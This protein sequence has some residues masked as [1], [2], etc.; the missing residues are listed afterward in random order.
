MQKH[1]PDWFTYIQ[2]WPSYSSLEREIF[3][4]SADQQGKCH[5]VHL[6]TASLNIG[7]WWKSICCHYKDAK[8]LQIGIGVSLTLLFLSNHNPCLKS[9]HN[10]NLSIVLELTWHFYLLLMWPV[11]RVK[12]KDIFL[13]LNNSIMVYINLSSKCTHETLTYHTSWMDVTTYTYMP[14]FFT[15]LLVIQE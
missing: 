13:V 5:R 2:L 6:Y 14:A 3:K 7:Q 12:I 1:D 11:Q 9:L 15:P 8:I 10:V 4:K